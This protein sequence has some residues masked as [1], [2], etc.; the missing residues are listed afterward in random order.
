[1][2]DLEYRLTRALAESRQPADE[3]FVS[4]VSQRVDT[5]ESARTVRLYILTVMALCLAAALSY[6]LYLSWNA[7]LVMS[8]QRAMAFS[9]T[10]SLS[11]LALVAIAFL[12]LR[13]RTRARE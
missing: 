12:F 6:G 5:H 3:R 13:P 10:A 7:A 1:M 8:M 2:S 11:S 4:K 9:T